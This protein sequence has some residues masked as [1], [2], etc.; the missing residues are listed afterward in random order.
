[1]LERQWKL[2]I[3]AWQGHFTTRITTG[4]TNEAWLPLLCFTT[5]LFI[6]ATLLLYFN[7]ISKLPSMRYAWPWDVSSRFLYIFSS[8]DVASVTF[9]VWSVWIVYYTSIKCTLTMNVYMRYDFKRHIIFRLHQ[10]T[11]II[12]SHNRGQ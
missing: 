4:L 7:F 2:E 9:E 6:V 5:G 1:M 10:I 3:L 12:M 11:K 8:S